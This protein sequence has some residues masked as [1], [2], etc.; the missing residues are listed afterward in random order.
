MRAEDIQSGNDPARQLA[1]APVRRRPIFWPILIGLAFAGAMAAGFAAGILITIKRDGKETNIEVPDGANARITAN[2]QVEVALP[3]QQPSQ[4]VRPVIANKETT[5]TV[6]EA[7]MT[8]ITGNGQV[9]VA[10][11]G[12]QSSQAAKPGLPAVPQILQADNRN[13]LAAQNRSNDPRNDYRGNPIADLKALHG[14][15]KVVRV[16]NGHDHGPS[17]PSQ[18]QCEYCFDFGSLREDGLTVKLDPRFISPRQRTQPFFFY[19]ID[20]TAAPKTI[21]LTDMFSK[22]G[23]L[24][25]LGIYEIAGDQLKICLERWPNSSESGQRPKDFAIAADSGNTLFVLERYRLSEDEKLMQGEWA[26]A[27]QIEDGKPVS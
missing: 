11:P 17:W 16:E 20:P 21:D 8:Q 25:R 19:S 4:A 13:D 6:P 5:I 14:R 15:W 24:T 18:S 1:T 9:G 23:P 27:K 22:T 26:I 10:L 12:Q 7:S 2:G 3:G